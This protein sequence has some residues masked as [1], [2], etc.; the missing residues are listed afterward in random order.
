MPIRTATL[1]KQIQHNG[2]RLHLAMASRVRSQGA[3][4][5]PSDEEQALQEERRLLKEA[6]AQRQ[7]LALAPKP[8]AAKVVKE[9]KPPKQPKAPKAAKEPKEA[10]AAKSGKD[11][12]PSRAEK[13]AKKAENLEAAKKASKKSAKT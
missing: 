2:Q 7:A 10:K 13:L 6:K 12:K 11:H 4:H 3:D 8:K 9:A 5:S 1:N